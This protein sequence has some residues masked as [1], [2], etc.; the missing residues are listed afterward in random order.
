MLGK[1]NQ[2]RARFRKID[3][4]IVLRDRARCSKIEQG[5]GLENPP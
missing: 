3:Q 1:Y 5:N 2:D 4:D